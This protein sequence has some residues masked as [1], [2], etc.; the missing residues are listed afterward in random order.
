MFNTKFLTIKKSTYLKVYF[1]NFTAFQ[2][3][4]RVRDR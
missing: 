3:I 1:K 2:V 4:S